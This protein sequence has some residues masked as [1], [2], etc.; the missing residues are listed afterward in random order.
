MT[1]SVCHLDVDVT[2]AKYVNNAIKVFVPQKLRKK[3]AIAKY[4]CKTLVY[5]ISSEKN[6]HYS[7]LLNNLMSGFH[8]TCIYSD[9]ANV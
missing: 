2:K 7:I 3:S 5:S 4:V 8:F 9:I 6:I 1:L